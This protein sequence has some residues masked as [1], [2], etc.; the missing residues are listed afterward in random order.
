MKFKLLAFALLIFVLVAAY[1]E[2]Q[3][4]IINCN[5]LGTKT[6]LLDYVS[7]NASKIFE[8]VKIVEDDSTK[9]LT[10]HHLCVATVKIQDGYGGLIPKESI[11]VFPYEFAFGLAPNEDN[12]EGFHIIGA[13]KLKYLM[14]FDVSLEKYLFRS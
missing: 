14:D 10:I 1:S 4:Q 8:I 2:K 11:D 6:L 3:E 5:S 7:I 12:T 9:D 13:Q